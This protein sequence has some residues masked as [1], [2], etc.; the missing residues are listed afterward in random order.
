MPGKPKNKAGKS[1]KRRK[2]KSGSVSTV[3][4]FSDL[5]LP[6]FDEDF[7]DPEYDEPAV[8]VELKVSGNGHHA[9]STWGLCEK[10]FRR[11]PGVVLTSDAS[12]FVIDVVVAVD[13]NERFSLSY[14][15]GAKVMAALEG[16]DDFF[17]P[18]DDGPLYDLTQ[19]LLFVMEHHVQSGCLVS[20]DK[21]CETMAQG[22]FEEHVAPMEAIRGIMNATAETGRRRR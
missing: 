5:A 16:L 1:P 15:I 11:L 7:E 3:I 13:E 10:H 18:S 12:Q 21:A 14:F 17:I 22:F 9:E 2:R 8:R 20:L 6:M 19:N 4:P